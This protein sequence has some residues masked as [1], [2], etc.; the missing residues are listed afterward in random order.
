[1]DKPRIRTSLVILLIAIGG[2]FLVVRVA[3]STEILLVIVHQLIP[4]F[5]S[6]RALARNV[7][8]GTGGIVY[9]S[10]DMLAEREDPIAV[11]RAIE[12]LKTNDD[13]T[14]LNAAIY[15]GACGRQEAVPYLIKALRHSASRSYDQDGRYLTAMTSQ[16]YGTDFYKWRSWWEKTHPDSHMDWRSHLGPVANLPVI[17]FERP[18]NLSGTQ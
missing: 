3:E 5:P 1:M 6:S 4:F 8:D 16:F 11:N 13:Y 2:I 9:D 18:K 15:L 12:L 10:L 17:A 7:N 14:W